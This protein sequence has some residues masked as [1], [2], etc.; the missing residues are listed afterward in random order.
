MVTPATGADADFQTRQKAM[1]RAA[2]RRLKKFS[3]LQRSE[4]S[5]LP[6][7]FAQTARAAHT[8]FIEQLAHFKHLNPEFIVGIPSNQRNSTG[9][10]NWVP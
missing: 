2:Q 4:K 3:S 8:K 5:D 9:L 6:S 10:L 7:M 1:F